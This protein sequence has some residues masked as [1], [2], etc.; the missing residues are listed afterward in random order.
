M[1]FIDGFWLLKSGV[2]PAY[3]LQV[4]TTAQRPEG[5]GYQLHVSSRPIRHRGDTLQGVVKVLV[6][7]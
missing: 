2:K 4:A 5:D 6:K 3:A 7:F 1:K